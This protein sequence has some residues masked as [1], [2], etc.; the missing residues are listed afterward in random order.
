[1][2]KKCS[3]CKLLKPIT[4]FSERTK[5][6]TKPNVTHNWYCKICTSL[7][8][9]ERQRLFKIKCIEYK[10]GK[11]EICAYNKCIAAFD[12]HHTNPTQKEF[13]ISKVRFTKFDE[14]IKIELDKCLLVCSNCHRELHFSGSG[15]I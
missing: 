10:G 12:F 9:K 2:L 5:A 7:Q 1:M 3:K 15:G 11:C 8:T 13:N 6:K 14:R 4:D